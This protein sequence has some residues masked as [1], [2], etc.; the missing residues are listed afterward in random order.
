MI[1]VY[2]L[3]DGLYVDDT[4]VGDLEIWLE[5]VSFRP[6]EIWDFSSKPNEIHAWK[7]EIEY[8]ED[9]RRLANFGYKSLE[10]VPQYIASDYS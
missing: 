3:S 7:F 10:Q 8:L 1:P 4:K 6:L 9:Y 2:R 5:K